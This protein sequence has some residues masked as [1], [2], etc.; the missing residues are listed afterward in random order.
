MA[1]NVFKEISTKQI[2]DA[3]RKGL[4]DLVGHR[5]TSD[6]KLAVGIGGVRYTNEDNLIK[7]SGGI[8]G[9]SPG[10]KFTVSVTPRKDYG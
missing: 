2:E 8:K 1:E 10:V 4:H 9:S 6:Y 3:I 7:S 5:L